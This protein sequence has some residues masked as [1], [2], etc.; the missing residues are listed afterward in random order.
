MICVQASEF[1]PISFV[2]L[3]ADLLFLC[4]RTKLSCIMHYSSIS[5]HLAYESVQFT[6]RACMLHKNSFTS[7]ISHSDISSRARSL[8]TQLMS[9]QRA[10]KHEVALFSGTRQECSRIRRL[11]TSQQIL[12]CG[13]LQL[14]SLWIW[15]G[16]GHMDC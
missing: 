9:C 14:F 10:S 2:H 5:L 3:P 15:R 11:V 13:G 16:R 7:H 6:N 1:L 12:L 8:L 4:R